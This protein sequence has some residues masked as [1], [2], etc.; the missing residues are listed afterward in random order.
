[1]RACT[2]CGRP[3]AGA[4]CAIHTRT[5]RTWAD[6]QARAQLVARSYVCAICGKPPTPTDPLTAD[7]ITPR[8]L[9]GPDHPTN[10]RAAHRT[11]NSRRGA[12]TA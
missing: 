7:H 3:A 4:Y 5:E 9:G 11:C 6:R 2:T 8:L 12:A 1:M 10:Y